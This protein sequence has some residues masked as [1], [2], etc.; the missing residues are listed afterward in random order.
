MVTVPTVF[1]SCFRALGEG[2]TGML[3]G[4][5]WIDKSI[6]VGFF[7]FFFFLVPLLSKQP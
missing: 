2:G 5:E 1:C 7:F 6:L 4:G 3:R